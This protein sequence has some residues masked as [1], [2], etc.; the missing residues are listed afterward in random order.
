MQEH[1]MIHV[2]KVGVV[3]VIKPQSAL[4]GECLA[5]CRRQLNDSLQ[6]LKSRVIIDLSETTLIQSE[7]LEFLVDAQ[8]SCLQQG[9][10]LALAAPTELCADAIEISGLKEC[11]SL[12][13][14]LR[15]ALGDFAR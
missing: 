7:G 9:G 14:D 5:A 2:Q 6:S 3:M 8:Q 10:R 4:V 12:F 15:S 1:S 11:I 13:S